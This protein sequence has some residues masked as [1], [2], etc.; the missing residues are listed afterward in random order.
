MEW[1]QKGGS[2]IPFE[3][4][5]AFDSGDFQI[6]IKLASAITNKN[7]VSKDEDALLFHLMGLSF[8]QLG[9]CLNAKNNFEKASAI[10]GEEA[11]DGSTYFFLGFCSFKT[12]EFDLSIEYLTKAIERGETEAYPIRGAAFSKSQHFKKAIKDFEVAEKLS[13]INER[14]DYYY[15]FGFS[16]MELGSILYNKGEYANSK[17]DYR[18]AIEKF[19]QAIQINPS[20]YASFKMMGKC[21]ELSGEYEKA[22]NSYENSLKIKDFQPE[23]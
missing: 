19:N 6:V 8:Y 11:T 15:Y 5:R 16:Y 23:V 21:Y 17:V 2:S 12:E 18:E 10:W 3:I 20:S 4:R 1:Q 13:L 7:K 22:I 9:D 14:S